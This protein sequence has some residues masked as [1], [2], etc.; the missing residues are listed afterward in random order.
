SNGYAVTCKHVIEEG[1][2]HIAILNDRNEFPIGIIS[3]SDIHDLALILVITSPTTPYLT[4]R[5]PLT[6]TPGDRVFAIG[7]SIGL[8]ATVTDGIFSGLRRKLPTED[9]VV[10]FSAPINPGNSGGPLI[11]E[12]GNVIG[13]VSWKMISNKGIPVTGVGFAIPSGYLIEEYG[14]YLE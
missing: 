5:D 14:A 11:D 10:Q 2:N 8:Q 13:V 4:L 9:R 1:P 6:M 12:K 3:T 7:S